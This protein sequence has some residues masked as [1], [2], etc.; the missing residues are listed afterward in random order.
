[1]SRE[2][3]KTEIAADRYVGNA[4]IERV[5]LILEDVAQ[6]IHFTGELT[7]A[8]I[9][10]SITGVFLALFM[11]AAVIAS[12][13]SRGYV[14]SYVWAWFISPIFDIREI[15]V[16]EAMGISIFGSLLIRLP[17]RFKEEP[18]NYAKKHQIIFGILS[19][20][21]E[22]IIAPAFTLAVA[23]F[24]HAYWMNVQLPRPL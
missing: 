4:N 5:G 18:T 7:L 21:G 3:E 19:F 15:T 9:A 23:W 16:S 13:I 2:A 12:T 14:L 11:A 6:T 10:L 1:M 20:F 8:M 24:I 17:T 22:T